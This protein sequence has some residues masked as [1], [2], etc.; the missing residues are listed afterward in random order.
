MIALTGTEHI[1]AFIKQ[2]DL[3]FAALD[4]GISR[5]FEDYT[6]KLFKQLVETTPQWSGDLA[7]SWNYSIGGID[8]SYTPS[9]NKIET[10]AFWSIAQIYQRGADP[11]VSQAVARAAGKHPTWRDAVYFHN[12]APIAYMVENLRVLIRPVNLVDQRIAMVQYYVDRHSL[13]VTWP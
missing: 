6:K 12:P 10:K 13:K 1:A 8:P 3:A 5:E 4:R 7:S 2:I 11:A 9:S